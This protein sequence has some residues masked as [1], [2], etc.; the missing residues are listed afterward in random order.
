MSTEAVKPSTKPVLPLW[1]NTTNQGRNANRS[2]HTALSGVR[3]RLK[4]VLRLTEE[5]DLQDKADPFESFHFVH[6]VNMRV[7][8]TRVCAHVVQRWLT[9]ADLS[10]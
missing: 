2:D 1:P 4:D 6:S 7:L 9:S 5:I 3:I 10:H 8:A